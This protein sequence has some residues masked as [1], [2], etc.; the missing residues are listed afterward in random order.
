MLNQQIGY[1]EETLCIKAV[2]CCSC[3]LSD[4]EISESDTF[5]K[6]NETTFKD[7]NVISNSILF[8]P[9]KNVYIS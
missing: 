2:K 6:T 9:R 4:D 7:T 3:Y 8:F 1:L 5:L